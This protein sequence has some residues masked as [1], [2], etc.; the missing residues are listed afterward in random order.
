M[1]DGTQ[2]STKKCPCGKCNEECKGGT[3]LPCA[4]CETWFHIKCLDGMTPEFV[5]C[6]D[7]M[8]RLYGGSSFLCV[9]CR[10]L[11]T[12]MNKSFKDM[13]KQMSAFELRLEKS[14]LENRALKE[15][16]EKMEAQT[17]QVRSKVGSM[18]KEIETGMETAKK[19]VKEEM[20]MEK[21]EIEE[22]ASNLVVYGLKESEKEEAKD[23]K[24][25]DDKKVK[26]M[27]EEIGVEVKGKVETKFRAGKKAE[28]GKPRPVIVK[29]EDDETREM[30]LKNARRLARKDDWRSVFVSP[31]LTWKQREEAR[32]EEKKL[33]EEADR[34]NEEAKNEGRTGG[35]W[36][37]IGRKGKRRVV[38][39]EDREK[40]E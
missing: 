15:K 32:K 11:V 28:D 30:M 39:W 18:E 34:K 1:P 9:V 4:F 33:R 23:R 25:E 27:M 10:K 17:D 29:V 16:I 40:P 21:K 31:D 26:E 2:R 7:K 13:E 37:V 14:E 5:D 6:C 22:R 35:R 36:T 19:E 12:K 8:N 38:W 20:S 24:E 3:G